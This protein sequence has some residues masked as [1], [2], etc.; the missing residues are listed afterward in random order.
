MAGL[1]FEDFEEGKVYRHAPSRSVTD[2]DNI[3]YSCMTLN[4]QP[5]HIN[6]DFGSKA[7][8]HKKPLFNSLYT[9]TI[10]IG[11]TT[12]DLT[13][14]TL[15]E[16]MLLTDIEFPQ[17]VFHGDTLY[18]KT[19]IGSLEE[20]SEHQDAGIVELLHE[21]LNQDEVVVASCRRKVLI[22]KRDLN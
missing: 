12:M 20:S 15:L 5:L 7:G 13:R 17:S 9:L 19:T 18:S 11:Q 16:N 14:G 1:Y 21:G 22:R 8:A 4:T 10:V 6:F 3:W 2:F